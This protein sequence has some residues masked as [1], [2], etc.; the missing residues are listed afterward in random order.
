MTE[1]I[2]PDQTAPLGLHCLFV[3]AG[4]STYSISA[5]IR[6]VF[7]PSKTIPKSR[8]WDCLGREKIVL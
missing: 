2:D 7:V 1:S 4:P 6:Q 3:R 5:D 8:L